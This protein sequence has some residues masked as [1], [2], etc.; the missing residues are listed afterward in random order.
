MLRETKRGKAIRLVLVSAIALILLYPLVWMVVSS[1]KPEDMIF[2]DLSLFPKQFT[3]ENYA[4]GW[5]S[6]GRVT[7]TTYFF[8]SIC[9]SVLAVIGNIAS[10][11]PVAYSFARLDY[12]GRNVFFVL[13]MMTLMLPIHAIIVPQFAYFYQ[14]GWINTMLPIIV[15]KFLATDAFFIFLIVQFMRGIPRDLDEAAIVDG[16]NRYSVFYRI[17]LPL[18]APALITT[19]IFTFMWTWNDFFT[20][21]IYL[22]TPTSYTVTLGLRMFIDMQALSQY[23]AMFAMSTLS[24]IP[25]LILFVMFQRL[26]IEGVATTGI[27]G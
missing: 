21:I 26:L 9:I 1:F 23:G 25:I 17:L 7:F 6:A 14:F 13:M 5:L 10:C 22:R 20:Q 16:C 15:P 3:L 4:I 27:K 19:T 8:N 11:A 12:K 2:K 18:T 24:I